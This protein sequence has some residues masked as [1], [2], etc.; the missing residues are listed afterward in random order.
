M[1]DGT[2]LIVDVKQIDGKYVLSQPAEDLWVAYEV[3][4]RHIDT[5]GVRHYSQMTDAKMTADGYEFKFDT[6]DVFT[7]TSHLL[8]PASDTCSDTSG[9]GSGG[10]GSGVEL[11]KF[12]LEFS[13]GGTSTPIVDHTVA[14]IDAARKAGKLIIGVYGDPWQMAYVYYS[15]DD[16]YPYSVVF[17]FHDI[18]GDSLTVTRHGFYYEE[19]AWVHSKASVTLT[20]NA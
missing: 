11:V 9:G 13:G 3:V 4:R 6:G 17:Y 19:G 18:S 10:G 14:E 1:N 5:D 16:D 8:K 2:T 7:C 15:G 20:G 12:E